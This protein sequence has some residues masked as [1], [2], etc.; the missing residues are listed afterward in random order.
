M[1]ARRR[2]VVFVSAGAL[3]MLSHITR[4]QNARSIQYVNVR[5]VVDNTRAPIGTWGESAR[6]RGGSALEI[7]KDDGR[8][9]DEDTEKPRKLN[10]KHLARDVVPGYTYHGGLARIIALSTAND[11]PE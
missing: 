7:P 10:D 11:D 8:V 1:Q 5:V 2:R 9:L 3:K 4:C 6:G